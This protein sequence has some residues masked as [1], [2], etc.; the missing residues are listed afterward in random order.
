MSDFLIF[1]GE[2]WILVSGLILLVFLFIHL[3]SKRG[4]QMVS[5]H[6][7]T[8][9]INREGALVLDI[10]DKKEYKEGHIVDSLNIPFATLANSI[11]KLEQHKDK[12]IVVVDKMGQHSGSAGKQ[13]GESGF[14]VSRLEGGISEWKASNMPLIQS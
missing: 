8:A 13:L 7:L 14:S 6:Q 10:R 1:I 9:L 2:Q 11:S 12:P 5:T 3:E 4:G